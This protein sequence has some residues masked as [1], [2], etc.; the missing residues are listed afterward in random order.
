MRGSGLTLAL[1]CLLLVVPASAPP[2]ASAAP[3]FRFGIQDDAWLEFGPGTV[4]QR[5]ATL[6]RLG[7]DVVRITLD[8]PRIE[9][10]RGEYDWS[11]EDAL[12]HALRNHGLIPLVTILG[13]PAWANGGQGANWA[14]LS[15]DAMVQFGTAAA[16]RYRFVRYWLIWNEPNQRRWLRPVSPSVYVSRL[17]NPAYTAI[18]AVIPGAKIGGGV[19][20]PRG[21]SGGMS[22][23][24][25]LRG[26]RRAGG[27]IDAYAH[28][29]YPLRPAETPTAGGCGHCETVTMAT[30]GR[31]L[32][33]VGRTYPK[34]RV[35]LTEYGYQTN[36]PD[37]FLGVS[38]AKQARYLAEAARRAAVLP[39]V[40]LLVHYLYRDEPA[41]GRWQSGLTTVRG[42]P[43]PALAAVMLPLV[44]VSRKG[45]TTVVWG[46][47]RP[48]SGAQ[49]YVVQTRRAGHWASLGGVRL[50]SA[51]GTLS[52]AVTA[53]RGSVLRLWYP[54]RRLAGPA[55]VV[56]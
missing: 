5:V 10:V 8:W 21:G 56:R 19:T 31:L 20:A 54:A 35:W 32:N 15:S 48:G 39:R 37:R 4:D 36:P 3:S 25:F 22:P 41:L 26:M 40:D 29:P 11:R 47:V 14:P 53:P 55:V 30:L 50:T 7:V 33:E 44:Q 43:K 23:L 16:E 12:L 46:Q 2:Q 24:A 52:T 45:S 42:Q 13:T 17:L 38:P 1:A 34:A 49:R 51:G 9:A 28:H 27:K 6:D 18:K